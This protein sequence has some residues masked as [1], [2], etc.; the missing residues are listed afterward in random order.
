[1]KKCCLI[2][3]LCILVGACQI[4]PSFDLINVSWEQEGKNCVYKE[5]FGNMKEEWDYEKQK[6]VKNEYVSSVRTIKYGDTSC[7]KVI[8]S[9]LKNRTNKSAISNQ[10]HEI[11]SINNTRIVTQ[12]FQ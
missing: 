12:Q 11:N 9:E 8:D 5:T 4:P 7:A 6:T 3:T 1:M 2:T 10:F